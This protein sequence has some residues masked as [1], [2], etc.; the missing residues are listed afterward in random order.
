MAE[1]A[2][3]VTW[4][5]V[6]PARRSQLIERDGWR[7]HYCGVLT[8]GWEQSGRK[9]GTTVDHRTPTVRGGSNELSNLVIA[10]RHCNQ[11]KHSRPYLDFMFMVWAAQEEVRQMGG[12]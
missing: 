12:P 2:A 9:E 8:V 3:G 6:S 10:C 5:Y 1:A 4:S 11:R 7:C